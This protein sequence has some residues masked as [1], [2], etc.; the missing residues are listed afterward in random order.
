MPTFTLD[1]WPFCTLHIQTTK[2]LFLFIK[3]LYSPFDIRI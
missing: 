2:S 3:T 1:K